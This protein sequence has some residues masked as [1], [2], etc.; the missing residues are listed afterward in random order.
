[1]F[2][3]DCR[4]RLSG[5]EKNKLEEHCLRGHSCQND[6][7]RSA[8]TESR[9]QRKIPSRQNARR[10]IS[11]RSAAM[12]RKKKK[13][14]QRKSRL[15]NKTA[16]Q[17]GKMHAG[18]RSFRRRSPGVPGTRVADAQFGRCNTD[19][20]GWQGRP[21]GDVPA[22]MQLFPKDPA[23]RWMQDLPPEMHLN[24]RTCRHSRRG[25]RRS[26]TGKVHKSSR[27]VALDDTRKSAADYTRCQDHCRVASIR[28]KSRKWT[29]KPTVTPTPPSGLHIARGASVLC[30]L[31]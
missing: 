25:K 13:I 4:A 9:R 27:A 21:A 11:L 12:G 26:F 22:R 8:T 29:L 1:M 14:A 5:C 18:A 10:L 2:S 16:Q 15:G 3:E 6:S 24:D 7:H 30:L 31:I 28:M 17:N 23:M 19:S 20:R